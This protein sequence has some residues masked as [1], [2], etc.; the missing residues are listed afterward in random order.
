[1]SFVRV[2]AECEPPEVIV[3]VFP[4][5]GLLR[6][7]L[8]ECATAF[9]RPPE[10]VDRAAHVAALQLL[11]TRLAEHRDLRVKVGGG[12]GVLLREKR[13]RADA[14]GTNNPQREPE[15]HDAE[16]AK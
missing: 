7:L 5:G 1:M 14:E 16:G 13:G 12:G 15:S 11:L 9:E 8:A 4:V 10:V 6:I 2:K 3:S